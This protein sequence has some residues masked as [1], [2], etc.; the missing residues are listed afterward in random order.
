MAVDQ[1]CARRHDGVVPVHEQLREIFGPH[2]QTEISAHLKAHGLH[3]GSQSTVSAWLGGRR[4]PDNNQLAQIE[5][6][7]GLERGTI[8]VQAGYIS[9]AAKGAAPTPA[10]DDQLAVIHDAAEQALR[11]LSKLSAEVRQVN[12]QLDANREQLALMAAEQG[13]PVVPVPVLPAPSV[14]D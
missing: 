2:T 5:D 13:V 14:P 8:L 12:A 6:I 10:G 4:V 9:Q 1:G 7:Y 11:L 3:E